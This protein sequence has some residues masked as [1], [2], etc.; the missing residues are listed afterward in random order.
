MYTRSQKKAEAAP[1]PLAH[2][3]QEAESVSNVW[4]DGPED[5]NPF[6]GRKPRYRDRRYHPRRND[7]AVDR[8]DRYRDDPIRSMG[9]K[10]EIPEF[11]GK[12]HPDEIAVILSLQ[13]CWT[14]TDVCRL[15]LKVEK[16]IKAKSKGNTSRFTLP[17]RTAPPTVSKAATPTTSAADNTR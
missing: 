7:R 14:Y 9:L 2:N 8:D 11:T 4:D 6:G 10:I 15:A 13:P 5:V 3:P 1:A 17:T 16:H 12:V